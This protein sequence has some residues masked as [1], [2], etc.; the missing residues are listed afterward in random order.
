MTARPVFPRSRQRPVHAAVALAIGIVALLLAA[1][2]AGQQQVSGTMTDKVLPS[3][4][5]ISPVS[6][7]CPLSD[8][9]PP[10]IIINPVS[11]HTAG[12]V[13]DITGTTNLGTDEKIRFVFIEPQSAA[14][15]PDTYEY[16]G[17]MG[18]VT[19]Q[20]NTCGPNSWSYSANLSGFDAPLTYCPR[21]WEES[22]PCVRNSTTCFF[23]NRKRPASGLRGSSLSDRGILLSVFTIPPDRLDIIGQS[24]F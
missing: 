17:T 2:C 6:H 18:R 3:T 10:Y 16:S 4:M 21:V 19:I 24:V 14:E 11:T 22:N 8:G 12:D 9:A 7:S 5:S 15:R 20:K 1:G 13:F 23:V